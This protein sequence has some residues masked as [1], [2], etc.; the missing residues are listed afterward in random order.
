MKI[1]GD[2][3]QRQHE[4]PA[5][6]GTHRFLDFFLVQ[7]L[8]PI[9]YP[10][11]GKI[12]IYTNIIPRIRRKGKL[13]FLKMRSRRVGDV[14]KKTKKDWLADKKDVWQ[15]VRIC[16]FLVL[17]VKCVRHQC[18]VAGTF[19]RCRERA[20]MLCACAGDPSRKDLSSLRHV[21]FQLVRVFVVNIIMFFVR[22]KRA[23]FFP[24]ARASSSRRRI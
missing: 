19:D 11:S 14:S 12:A 21:A 8:P 20:L 2:Q 1:Y 10:K 3:Q 17:S 22:T 6:I 4:R 15:P 5:Q 18:N 13:A 24:S 7:R 23:N 9:L 16:C